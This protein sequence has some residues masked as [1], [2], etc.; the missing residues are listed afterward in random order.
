[1]MR[2]F[3]SFIILSTSLISSISF[4]KEDCRIAPLQM[5]DEPRL[6][7]D[8]FIGNCHYRNQDYAR[9]ATQWNK[10]LNTAPPSGP[11]NEMQI[12]SMNNLGFLLFNG[13]DIKPD[14]Q[15]A[16]SLWHKAS[17]AGQAESTYHLCHAY[18]RPDT[19]QFNTIKAKIYCNKAEQQYAQLDEDEHQQEI[20]EI[21]QIL[22]ELKK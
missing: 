10:V 22:E 4:A 20:D 9:A 8:F 11:F 21:N 1:M 12:N 14:Q 3:I 7:Q 6:V 18:A 19:P 13:L 15:K 16:L 5:Q 17:K 2:F